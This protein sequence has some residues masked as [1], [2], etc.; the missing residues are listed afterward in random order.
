MN[1]GSIKQ[2]DNGIYLGRISTLAVAMTIAPASIRRPSSSR[3]LFGPSNRA[4]AR[5]QVP[6]GSRSKPRSGA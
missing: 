2:N 3:K 6:G 4:L 5:M 1:I